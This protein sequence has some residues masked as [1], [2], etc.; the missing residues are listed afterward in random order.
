MCLG[1]HSDPHQ[2]QTNQY[3]IIKK[4][5]DNQDRCEFCH[6]VESWQTITYDHSKT[7]FKLEGKHRSVTCRAC[8]KGN[9]I[10]ASEEIQ[11]KISKKDCQD[12][13]QDIHMGQFALYD[14]AQTGD[15]S[16]TNCNRCH[17]VNNWSPVKFDHNRDARF[18]LEG[19]HKKLSCSQCH[20]AV[21]IRGKLTN[22]YKPLETSCNSCHIKRSMTPEGIKS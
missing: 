5:E 21:K 7:N 18:K 4:S 16:G 22:H 20:K 9:N 2:G 15:N 19:A 3:V 1:C 10:Q 13:H 8:H 6:S 11:F 12:C 17:T 14:S